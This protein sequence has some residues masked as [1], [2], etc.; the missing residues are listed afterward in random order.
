M[1]LRTTFLALLAL[2]VLGAATAWGRE[3]PVVGGYGFDWLQPTTTRCRRITAADQSHF[4]SCM[5]RPSGH[6]FGLAFPYQE[7][8]IS[9]HSQML[10][11]A[12]PA[13][14]QEAFE[15]MQANGE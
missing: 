9:A 11:Y 15:T 7:C 12:S 6:A 13:V 14:C 1:G 8:S 4:R 5:F 3:V 2:F 10:I